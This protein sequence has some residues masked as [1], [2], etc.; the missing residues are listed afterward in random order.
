MYVLRDTH[1]CCVGV[2][3]CVKSI[4]GNGRKG[5]PSKVFRDDR[6]DDGWLR[7]VGRDDER[8]C[9]GIVEKEREKNSGSVQSL[10]KARLLNEIER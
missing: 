9:A 1:E 5:R 7:G 4:P 8:Y 2:C 10:H 6:M 3:M